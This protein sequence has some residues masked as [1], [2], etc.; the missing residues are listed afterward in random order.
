MKQN[1]KNVGGHLLLLLFLLCMIFTATIEG[2]REG[3]RV[4]ERCCEGIEGSLSG[5]IKY[6]EE[7]RDD[8][9]YCE[10]NRDAS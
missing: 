9:N 5:V 10:L 2:R 1:R 6:T 8:C 4:A 7:K 3:R